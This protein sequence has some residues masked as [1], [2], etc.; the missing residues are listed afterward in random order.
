MKVIR[1]NGLH[2]N[3]DDHQECLTRKAAEA[4][5]IQPT[6]IASLTVIKKALDARRNKPPPFFFSPWKKKGGWG[7]GGGGGGGAGGR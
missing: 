5:G 1:L 6:D 2:L 3:L 4:L 7:G